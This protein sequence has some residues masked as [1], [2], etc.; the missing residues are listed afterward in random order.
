[1]ATDY[2]DYIKRI[3][4][5]G[6]CSDALEWLLTEFP[7]SLATAW[8]ACQR[9]DWMLW[10]AGHV[11]G[12]PGDSSRIP[13]VLAACDCAEPAL[14]HVPAW[15][16]RPRLA[17]DTARRWARGE[18]TL[19]DVRTAALNA[20][21]AYAVTSYSAPCTA[22]AAAVI[23]IEAWHHASSAALWSVDKAGRAVAMARCAD[24]V[25][26]HYHTPPEVF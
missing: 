17:I 15:E 14:V 25:R 21:I 23:G 16:D 24:I 1:M 10:L 20:S 4:E 7:P 11:V 2:P 18:A 8:A 13:L 3:V 9:G 19:D 22:A 26:R 5:L 6:A 12:P